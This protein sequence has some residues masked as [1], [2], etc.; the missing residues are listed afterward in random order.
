MHGCHVAMLWA[1][2]R[3]VQAAQLIQWPPYV[4]REGAPQP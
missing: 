4:G 2:H 3:A 1:R